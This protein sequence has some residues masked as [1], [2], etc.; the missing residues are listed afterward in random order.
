MEVA[1]GT[2]LGLGCRSQG[3]IAEHAMSTITLACSFGAI[4]TVGA[5]L[6]AASSIIQR[7]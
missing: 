5:A 4:W 6:A 7:S 3:H 1:K 2:F